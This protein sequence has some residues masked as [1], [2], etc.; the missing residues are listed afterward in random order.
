MP[1]RYRRRRASV[2]AR[3]VNWAA[4]GWA[5]TTR[6]DL[7]L[8]QALCSARVLA[9]AW[10]GLAA[11]GAVL[12]INAI[13]NPGVVHTPDIIVLGLLGPIGAAA[14]SGYGLGARVLDGARVQ[15]VGQ[16]MLCGVDVA[17]LTYMQFMVLVGVVLTI[18]TVLHSGPAGIGF[19]VSMTLVLGVVWLV[20]SGD[21]V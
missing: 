7:L 2:G 8:S 16:A 5:R 15:N 17:L 18:S 13:L 6:G 19:T 4:A 21:R 9:A 11:A 14:L 3:A 1:C 10:F 20:V 12:L